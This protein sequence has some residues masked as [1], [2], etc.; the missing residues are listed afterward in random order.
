MPV[1]LYENDVKV[2][3]A[4]CGKDVFENPKMSIMV[5]VKD[6]NTNSIIDVYAC[7]KGKCDNILKLSRVKEKGVDGWKDIAA[8]HNPLTFL[9]QMFGIM[10]QLQKGVKIDEEAFKNYKEL[11]LA[12]AQYVMRD[13]TEKKKKEA[14]LDSMVDGF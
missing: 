13:P 11:L 9:R 10:N 6:L 3:C 2:Y 8:F 7:C 5:M 1:K 4:Y 14:I 12:G